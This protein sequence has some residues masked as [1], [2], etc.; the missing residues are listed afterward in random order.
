MGGILHR[1]DGRLL[2]IERGTN[3]GRGLWSLPGGRLEPGETDATG[4]V[5]EMAEETGLVV[6][7]GALAGTVVIGPYR[8]ADYF[9]TAVGGTLAAGDDAAAAR[10]VDAAG[11]ATLP[12]VENLESTLRGW[13]A[14]PRGWR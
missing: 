9:C 8:I 7:V 11:F 6:E 4:L 10:W 13:D 3:P 12:L 14:L 5:R 1:G 2:L